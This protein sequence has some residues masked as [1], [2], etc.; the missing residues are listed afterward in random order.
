MLI[1]AIASRGAISA[2]LRDNLLVTL[3]TQAYVAIPPTPGILVAAL[4]RVPVL[5]ATAIG[6][7]IDTLWRVDVP[8]AVAALAIARACRS[9]ATA[10]IRRVSAAA[11]AEMALRRVGGRM[12][13]QLAANMVDIAAQEVMR[14]LPE[15]DDVR[16]VCARFAR[17]E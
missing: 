9:L 10:P 11:F 2:E 1:A 12:P 5:T 15:L 8:P 16:R 7:V 14:L 3:A 6:R 13:V 17:G 4:H